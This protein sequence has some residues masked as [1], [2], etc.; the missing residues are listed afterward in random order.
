MLGN[1]ARLVHDIAG[2]LMD[3]VQQLH[4]TAAAILSGELAIPNLDLSSTLALHPVL[5]LLHP[6]P[7]YPHV[8][9]VIREEM[10][11]RRLFENLPP[12][13]PVVPLQILTA[14]DLEAFEGLVAVDGMGL[15][16][17]LVRKLTV[18][19]DQEASLRSFLER[20]GVTFPLNPHIDQRCR[21]YVDML[22][23]GRACAAD[24]LE[25]R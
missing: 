19:F 20:S 6:W 1:A 4:A 21:E 2:P 10:H 15:A 11:A 18:P 23:T 3:K 13:P 16:S 14:D 7:Q 5:M 9:D 22:T 24:A 17:H 25:L 12:G 8:W